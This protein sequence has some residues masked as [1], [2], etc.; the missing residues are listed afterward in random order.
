M[1]A[2]MLDAALDLASAGWDI[3]PCHG[4][5]PLVAHGFRDA[6]S[7]PAQTEAWWRR[8][9]AANIAGA[10][11]ASLLVVDVDPRN[12]GDASLGVL[13][14]AHGRFPTTL[15]SITGSGGQH[16][17]FLRPGGALR[18]GSHKLGPGLDLKLGGKGYVILP[19]SVHPATGRRY[20]WDDPTVPVAAMPTWLVALCRPEP[21][22]PRPSRPPLH[23]GGQRPGDHLASVP[24]SALL[25]P[26]GWVAVGERGE[27][28]YWRRPGKDEGISAS[29]NALGSDRLHVFTSS[30]PPFEPDTSY[31]KFAA[32]TLLRAGGDFSQAARQLREKAAAA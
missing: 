5:A 9:P 27:I 8:W 4:K 18:N 7:D 16:I 6:S 30:A 25:E 19:P 26:E 22:K 21:P 10:V 2:S 1:T 32:Y 14:A 29:T 20:R 12:G 11:P 13:E 17:F 28:T 3:F 15:R 24:W 23:A 31:T